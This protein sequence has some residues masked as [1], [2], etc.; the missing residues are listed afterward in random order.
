MTC[1]I[2]NK[3]NKSCK[4]IGCPWYPHNIEMKATRDIMTCNVAL[5]NYLHSGK[6]VSVCV[7]L[8]ILPPSSLYIRA[9]N[10]GK[11]KI[12]E[13]FTIKGKVPTRAFSWLK[14]PTS[15]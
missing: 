7:D 14:V 4:T 9:S 11:T 10:E 13:D 6:I 5:S 2:F 1:T 8:S 15:A 3:Q 12:R